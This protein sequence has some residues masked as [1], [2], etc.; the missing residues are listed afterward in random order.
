MKKYK[1][2][3][4][5]FIGFIFVVCGLY[6]C[7]QNEIQKLIPNEIQEFESNIN[8]SLKDNYSIEEINALNIDVMSAKIEVIEKNKK[9]VAVKVS[10]KDYCEIFLDD[11]C[12]NIKQNNSWIDKN[13]TLNI[14]I[15]VPENY[16]FESTSLKT[17]FG[18]LIVSSVNTIYLDAKVGAGELKVLN[19][20]IRNGMKIDC[21][22]GNV[23]VKLKSQLVDFG[24]KVDCGMGNVVIGDDEYSGVAQS[25]SVIDDKDCF[26]DIN[27]GM[28]NVKIKEE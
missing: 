7:G 21:G 12:L 19:L 28:G 16:M 13:K 26:I 9:D 2:I 4:L 15:E 24:Y 5:I 6:L 14:V 18:Q 1:F 22:I 25:Q 3:I 20:N 8:Y 11:N 17:G 10:D 23:D 27:C